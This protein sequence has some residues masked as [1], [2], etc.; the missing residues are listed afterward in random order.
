MNSWLA[1]RPTPR[2]FDEPGARCGNPGEALLEDSQRG[3]ERRQCHDSEG[4]G[5]DKPNGKDAAHRTDG[6]LLVGAHG[7]TALSRS[8]PVVPELL[9]E[10]ETVRLPLDDD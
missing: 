5:D 7:R 1:V 10:R 3:E 6:I 9:L 2:P 8:R 4:G